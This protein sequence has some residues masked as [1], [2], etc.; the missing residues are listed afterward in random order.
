MA[1]SSAETIPGLPVV[2]P[3]VASHPRSGD[4]DGRLALLDRPDALG[5]DLVLGHRELGG[6]PMQVADRP[7]HER[8]VAQPQFHLLDHALAERG[9]V[10][11]LDPVHRGQFAEDQG[12]GVGSGIGGGRLVLAVLGE[13]GDGQCRQQPNGHGCGGLG[14]GH[15]EKR[16]QL[17]GSN[18][19]FKNDP[20]IQVVPDNLPDSGGCPE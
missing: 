10:G 5:Q 2:E 14:S 3:L 19:C 1:T 18:G 12:G 4:L 7:A 9:D 16:L 13:R 8:G 20:V 6:F 15:G 11:F 17:Q